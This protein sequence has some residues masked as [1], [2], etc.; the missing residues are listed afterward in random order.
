MWI[1]HRFHLSFT[2][3]LWHC[4]LFQFLLIDSSG[5]TPVN[6]PSLD[7]NPQSKD[8]L[9]LVVRKVTFGNVGRSLADSFEG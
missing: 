5:I 4:F 8:L 6:L 2:N 3:M 9:G 1:T 7:L